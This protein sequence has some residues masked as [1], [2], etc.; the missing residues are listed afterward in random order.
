MEWKES[1]TFLLRGTSRWSP[2][3]PWVKEILKEDIQREIQTKDGTLYN[4]RVSA[5]ETLVKR[6]NLKKYKRGNYSVL[7][8]K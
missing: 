6:Y 4:I 8:R 3:Y 5:T 2:S 1:I 7:V